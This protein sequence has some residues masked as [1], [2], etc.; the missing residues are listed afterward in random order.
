[1]GSRLI[2][3]F[4]LQ[5]SVL[6]KSQQSSL[7]YSAIASML[8]YNLFLCSVGVSGDQNLILFLKQ[9]TCQAV[10]T[11][12]PDALLPDNNGDSLLLIIGLTR[13][14][15]TQELVLELSSC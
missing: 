8:E 10:S 5:V 15:W 6:E 2:R 9:T 12:E 4:C 7:R 11:Q 14:S 1:M 3:R 13:P